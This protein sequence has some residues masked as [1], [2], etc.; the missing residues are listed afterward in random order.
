MVKQNPAQQHKMIAI[1]V[2]TMSLWGLG[3]G[4]GNLD[5]GLNFL[6]GIIIFGEALG[7]IFSVYIFFNA[8]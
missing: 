7:V 4:L 2:F 3:K 5:S 6:T 8:K 1:L